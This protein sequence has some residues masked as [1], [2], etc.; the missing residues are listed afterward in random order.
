MLFHQ[1]WG[2]ECLWIL[3]LFLSLSITYATLRYNLLDM[4]VIM[5]RSLTYALLSALVLVGELGFVWFANKVLHNLPMVQARGF[6]VLFAM[7]VLFVM[8]P[9]RERVQHLEVATL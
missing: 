2:T 3:T 8:N 7:A 5:R 9:L 6:P 4:G 1:N